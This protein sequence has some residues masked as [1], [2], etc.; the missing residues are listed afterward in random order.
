MAYLKALIAF[1]ES[2]S[3]ALN[4]LT[5]CSGGSVG[6]FVVTVV[7]VVVALVQLLVIAHKRFELIS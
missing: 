1:R 4:S 2:I 5:H 3:A 6:S 7:E